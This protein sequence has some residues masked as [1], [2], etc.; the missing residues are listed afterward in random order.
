M[1]RFTT[2]ITTHFLM[3]YFFVLLFFIKEKGGIHAIY[4]SNMD[5]SGN[6]TLTECSANNLPGLRRRGPSAFADGFLL[7]TSFALINEIIKRISFWF[8]TPP[9]TLIIVN[10][11]LSNLAND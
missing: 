9:Y 8:T 11:N 7:N 3:F 10:L 6:S 5:S 4:R 2:L 1:M